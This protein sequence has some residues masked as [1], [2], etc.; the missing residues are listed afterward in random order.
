M[1]SA[2]GTDHIRNK[3]A[4]A[5]V[6]IADFTTDVGVNLLMQWLA[7]EHVV[8]IFIAPPGGSASRARSIPLKRKAPGDPRPLRSDRHPN[9]LPNLLFVDRVKVSKANKLY[10]LTAK[11]V[12]WAIEH[13]CL[14]C[15]ENPQFSFFWQTTFIQSIIHLMD[16]TTFQS[17]MYGST[18]P[19]RTM[20]GHNAEEGYFSLPTILSL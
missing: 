7:D 2:F 12:Q 13:G 9:G 18:R 1:I 11:L 20:L 15:I 16:F 3:Q 4:A 14:F 8:G 6:V 19:K 17:C 10:F 5:Q